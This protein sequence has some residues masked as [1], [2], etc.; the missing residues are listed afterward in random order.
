MQAESPNNLTS[1]QRSDFVR[2]ECDSFVHRPYRLLYRGRTSRK[3]RQSLFGEL[4]E[5]SSVVLIGRDYSPSPSP[6]D[7]PIPRPNKYLS[8]TRT[9][10]WF[11]GRKVVLKTPKMRQ[12]KRHDDVSSCCLFHHRCPLF[13][14][15]IY[16]DELACKIEIYVLSS[17]IAVT[18]AKQHQGNSCV[19]ENVLVVFVIGAV[20]TRP[21]KANLSV[22]DKY[23]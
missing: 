5:Q 1:R 19:A 14:M 8:A 7:S 12:D 20:V 6:E 2:K 10:N 22:S 16:L 4:M 15:T 17:E 9:M 18:T 11:P 21:Y 3:H 13:R 23:Q